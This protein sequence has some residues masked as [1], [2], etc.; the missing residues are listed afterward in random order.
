MADEGEHVPARTGIAVRLHE[1]AL[2]AMAAGHIRRANAL[3]ARA[4]RLAR[5]CGPALFVASVLGTRAT[6]ARS[7]GRPRDA[8]S[9]C[10]RALLWVNRAGASPHAGRLRRQL[11]IQHAILTC[12]LGS[13]DTALRMARAAL[14]AVRRL[15]PGSA[16]LVAALNA[17]G[18]C[19]KYSGRWAEGE[20]CYRRAL[21]LQE[22]AGDARSDAVAT[23][24]HNLGGIEHARGRSQRA[25]M[26]ARRGL[27]IRK[28]L[29]PARHPAV[30]ADAAALAP[31]LSELGRVAEAEELL[32]DVVRIYRRSPRWYRYELAVAYDNLAT[33]RME[34]GRPKTVE[35]LYRCSI[36]LKRRAFGSRHPDLALTLNN[37]AAYLASRRREAAAAALCREALEIFRSAL[38]GSHPH[39][40]A[41]ERNCAALD[42]AAVS[43]GRS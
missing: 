3:A 13:Y 30:A 16:E 17:V 10:R 4:L 19:C 32:L 11:R 41:C 36:R 27:A 22:R 12:E 43:R 39:T 40:L 21:R 28:L 18:F 8:A 42:A 24:L 14:A 37:L 23:L 34:A 29:H 5:E 7:A 25:A 9:F 6:L 31:I 26:W 33:L 38:G 20:R 15:G 35:R 2:Q 1:R